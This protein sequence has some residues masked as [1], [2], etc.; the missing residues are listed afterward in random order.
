M[1]IQLPWQFF[2]RQ[3]MTQKIIYSN[4]NGG[5][6]LCIP[7]DESLIQEVLKNDCPEGAFIVDDS[8]LPTDYEFFNAWELVNGAVVINETKK[9]AIID[10]KQEFETAKT[11]STDKLKALG[12]T[13]IEIQALTGVV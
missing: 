9:Q 5:V 13:D 12:L 2:D 1:W 8:E 3:K 4:A 7:T 10:A 11:T 6:S